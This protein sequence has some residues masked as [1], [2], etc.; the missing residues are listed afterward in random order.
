[1]MVSL[2]HIK[3][4]YLLISGIHTTVVGKNSNDYKSEAL[5]NILCSK[6]YTDTD[7][8]GNKN[9]HLIVP[10]LFTYIYTSPHCR[11]FETNEIVLVT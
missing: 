7:C 10:N 5:I 3:A 11:V 4:F 6:T 2:E 8:L 9:I 1:M